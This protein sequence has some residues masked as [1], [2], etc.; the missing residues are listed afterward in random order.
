MLETMDMLSSLLSEESDGV[1]DLTVSHQPAAV[2][3]MPVPKDKSVLYPQVI[4][5]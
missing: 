3:L 1:I 5:G 2:N 4:I